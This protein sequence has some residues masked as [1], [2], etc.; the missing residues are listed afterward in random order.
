MFSF[1]IEGKTYNLVNG[2]PFYI[3]PYGEGWL[4]KR[5]FGIDNYACFFLDPDS[6]RQSLMGGVASVG[7]MKPIDALNYQSLYD[8]EKYLYI[9]PPTYS[10]I[11]S[12]ELG[13][14]LYDRLNANVDKVIMG[15]MTLDQ[16]FTEYDQIKKDGFTKITG[17]MAA[18]YQ[19]AAK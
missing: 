6:Y 9:I 17:E 19:M 8:N 15:A 3:A 7:Q 1:G 2:K 5:T 11:S 18:A 12:V 10:T 13:T 14:S 16:F 4:N